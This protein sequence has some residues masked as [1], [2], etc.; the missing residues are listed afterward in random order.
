MTRI[1]RLL[2]ICMVFS[3]V[4]HVCAGQ[5]VGT[6]NFGPFDANAFDTIN[7]GNLDVHFSIPIFTKVGRGGSNFSYTLNYDGLVWIPLGSAGSQVWTPV[8]EWGWADVTNAQYGY[9]T[10]YFNT[11]S[12]T[13]PPH[14]IRSFYYSYSNFVY[15][16]HHGNSHSIEYS[17]STT[18]GQ[19]GPPP[20]LVLIS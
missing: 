4:G 9:V 3:S 14:G 11:I 19:T 17:Y 1:L 20:E 16:D 12:C 2:A 8:S 7:R 15:H 10:Y 5:A 6:Y 13:I 18:C